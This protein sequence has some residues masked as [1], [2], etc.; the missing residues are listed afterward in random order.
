MKPLQSR[1]LVSHRC[2]LRHNPQN[3]HGQAESA[4]MAYG[5]LPKGR[6]CA[7]S[8]NTR[9]RQEKPAVFVNELPN[10]SARAVVR[11]PCTDGSLVEALGKMIKHIAAMGCHWAGHC[12]R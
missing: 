8:S 3:A 10:L 12:T 11:Y 2:L 5:A 1:V 6:A 9:G 4:D 7:R